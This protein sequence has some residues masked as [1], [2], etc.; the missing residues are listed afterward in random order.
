MKRIC[1]F[2][3]FVYPLLY[4]I[5]YY[6]SGKP[7][8]DIFVSMQSEL[9]RSVFPDSKES[10]DIPVDRVSKYNSRKRLNYWLNFRDSRLAKIKL[11]KRDRLRVQARENKESLKIVKDSERY[12]AGNSYYPWMPAGKTM[13][14]K[15]DISKASPGIILGIRSPDALFGVFSDDAPYFDLS[16]PIQTDFLTVLGVKK[17]RG[18][19]QLCRM[20]LLVERGREKE[21]RLKKASASFSYRWSPD[22]GFLL[23][24]HIAFFVPVSTDNGEYAKRYQSSPVISP[25]ASIRTTFFRSGDI[26]YSA[27]YYHNMKFGNKRTLINKISYHRGFKRFHLIYGFA[28]LVSRDQGNDL[29]QFLTAYYLFPVKYE[30]AIKISATAEAGTT[31]FDDLSYLLN[32]SYNY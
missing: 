7:Y 4:A 2:I 32:L 27:Y 15:K 10:Y 9:Q 18:Y 29:K 3:I 21:F 31:S 13:L 22:G 26:S 1:I 17:E 25:G 5:P 23:I 20:S 19:S 16:E 30:R 12:P 8:S 14:R 28:G 11:N 6:N 24:P